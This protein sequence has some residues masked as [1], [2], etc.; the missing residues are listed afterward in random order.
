MK[1]LGGILI[2]I[3]VVLAVALKINEGKFCRAS[4]PP[5]IDAATAFTFGQQVEVADGFYK[6]CKGTVLAARE[7][8]SSFEYQLSSPRL[9]WR[10]D[11]SLWRRD[12]TT[13]TGTELWFPESHL[14]ALKPAPEPAP[15]FR[16]DREHKPGCP[17]CRDP[18]C[19]R[20][21]DPDHP[22]NN[23]KPLSELPPPEV[24]SIDEPDGDD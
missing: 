11:Y 15:T 8:G 2:L 4:L 19:L 13:Q 5:S 3:S 16:R 23:V 14:A 18:A 20:A 17:L 9:E 12:V 22:L 7:V 1:Y 21:S 6:G 10:D 24:E